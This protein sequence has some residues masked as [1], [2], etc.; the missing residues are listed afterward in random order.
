MWVNTVQ[1]LK[2]FCS[3]VVESQVIFGVE[4]N[5][6]KNNNGISSFSVK[7]TVMKCKVIA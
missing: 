4:N 3:V 7:M 5:T 1:S 2:F 6:V